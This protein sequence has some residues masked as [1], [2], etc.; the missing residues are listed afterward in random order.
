MAKKKMI[1]TL[2]ASKM[3]YQVE[4]MTLLKNGKKY[5]RNYINSSKKLGLFPEELDYVTSFYDS[6][7]GSSGT[8]F[9][10]NKE[11]NYI[12]AFTGTNVVD[13]QKDFETDIYSLCLGQG[14]HYRPCFNFYKKVRDKY[15]D[16]IILTGHSLGGNIAQ[17]TAIEFDVKKTIIYNSAG[18]YIENAVDIFMNV[19]EE[20]KTL[21]AK[22]LRRYNRQVKLIKE[23]KAAFTGEILHFSSEYD[24]LGRMAAAVD[25]DVLFLGKNYI[26]KNGGNHPLKVMANVAGEEIYKVIKGEISFSDKFAIRHAPLTKAE[27]EKFLK[28]AGNSKSAYEM[29]AKMFIGADGSVPFAEY[30]TDDLDMGKFIRY[31]VS[32]VH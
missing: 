2:Y 14:Y 17:R 28:R 19:T 21:Y 8:L 7:T 1:A 25:G 10:D 29:V 18:L 27:V 22:R 6:K 32:R 9:K 20:N 24:F 4:A 23:K 15:G 31:F 12:L 5:I 26:I 3:T 11:D 13:M 16:N 30:Q